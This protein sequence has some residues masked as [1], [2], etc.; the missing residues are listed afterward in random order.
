MY[1]LMVCVFRFDDVDPETGIEIT[2]S[3]SETMKD[4]YP[5]HIIENED[6][7]QGSC[8]LLK[9]RTDITKHVRSKSL[10]DLDRFVD[11]VLFLCKCI[12]FHS[13]IVCMSG[14]VVG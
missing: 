11:L 8:A 1:S 9:Q 5:I 12:E 14:H 4:I 3:F 6:G 2:Q 7:I 10:K 13:L